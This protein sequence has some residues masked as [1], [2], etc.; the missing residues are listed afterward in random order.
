MLNFTFTIH[1]EDTG[2][3]STQKYLQS[4]YL[5]MKIIHVKK[6]LSHSHIVKINQ[7]HTLCVFVIIKSTESFLSFV[8]PV[9]QKANEH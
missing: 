9:F 4:S 3:Q 7:C 1:N 5:P 2:A 6:W 8:V